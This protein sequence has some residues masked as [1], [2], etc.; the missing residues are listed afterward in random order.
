MANGQFFS[1]LVRLYHATFDRESDIE[2]IGYWARQL[3]KG[4]IVFAEVA[5]AFMESDEFAAL[6]PGV[7][8]DEEFVTLL[9]ENVLKREPDDEGLA[10]WLKVLD[11][12]NL[13]SEVL[14][15]FADSD[16]F[17]ATTEGELT[18]ELIAAE[19]EEERVQAELDVD[20]DDDDSDDDDSDDDDSDDDDSD[21]DDSDDDDSDDDDSGDDDSDDDDSDD[22]DSDD[23]DSGDD[24]GDL[25]EAE[26]AA[27]VENLY[28]AA[29][30]RPADVSGLGHW[31]SQ[32]AQ[33]KL[34]L[35]GVA[36]A[37]MASEE[38]ALTYGD[39]LEDGDFIEAL[40][41]NVLEREPDVDGQAYWLGQLVSGLARHDVLE[42]FANSTE[43]T[44]ANDAEVELE[45]LGSIGDDLIT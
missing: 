25:T 7:L 29:F 4:D 14:L 9:Y 12:G 30:N 44:Q 35:S 17:I 8:S 19:Q 10:H 36:A 18:D 39:G 38:F 22:D 2:G 13:R 15:S 40:Y 26:Y 1:G 21:D 6:Y 24:A 5:A 3:A 20:S 43:N 37:F 33:N 11:E 28:D 32:L 16:E 41:H 42:A 34:D 23:D 45:L 31:V 27:F